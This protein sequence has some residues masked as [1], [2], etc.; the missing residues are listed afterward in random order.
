MNIYDVDTD[1][2]LIPFEPSRARVT[3]EVGVLALIEN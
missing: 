1:E 3:I 2:H